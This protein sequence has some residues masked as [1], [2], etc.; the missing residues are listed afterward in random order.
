ML[1]FLLLEESRC[2]ILSQCISLK[3]TEVLQMSPLFPAGVG[4]IPCHT[5]TTTHTSNGI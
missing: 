1:D 4:G 5:L 3:P 2:A